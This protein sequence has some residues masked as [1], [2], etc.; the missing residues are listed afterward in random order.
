[1]RRSMI[2][3]LSRHVESTPAV[4]VQTGE[5]DLMRRGSWSPQVCR[6]GQIPAYLGSHTDTQIE[7]GEVRESRPW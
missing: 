5:R 7:I 1:M 4:I 3:R 2:C 6:T